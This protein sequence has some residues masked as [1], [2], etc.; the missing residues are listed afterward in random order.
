MLRGP[1]RRQ[2]PGNFHRAGPGHPDHSPPRPASRTR[3]PCLRTHGCSPPAITAGPAAWRTCE[4]GMPAPLSRPGQAGRHLLTGQTPGFSNS[5]EG[6]RPAGHMGRSAS[7]L[8]P[9]TSSL[10][11]QAANESGDGEPGTA[12]RCARSARR[13]SGPAAPTMSPDPQT[14]SRVLATC[15]YGSRGGKTVLTGAQGSTCSWRAMNEP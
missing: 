8:G 12:P 11:P 10:A 3:A 7:L 14:V 1:V 9:G 5:T 15:A 13:R 2:F 4:A 6:D